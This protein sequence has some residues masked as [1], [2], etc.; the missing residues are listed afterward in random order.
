MELLAFCQSYTDLKSLKQG[1]YEH[2]YLS[3][4]QGKGEYQHLFVVNYDQVKTKFISQV[5]CESRGTILSYIDGQY[6]LVCYAFQKFFNFGAPQAHQIDWSTAKIYE[7]VDGSLLKLYYD[8]YL[9]RWTVASNRSITLNDKILSTSWN[10]ASRHLPWDRLQT[11]CVYMFELV[12]PKWKIVI[13]YV[14]DKIYHLATRDMHTLK[15]IHVDLP[16]IEHPLIYPLCS[17]DRIREEV[18]KLDQHHEGWVVIDDKYQRVKVKTPTYMSLQHVKDKSADVPTLVLQCVLKGET[19]ELLATSAQ[20]QPIIEE[21]QAKY[22]SLIQSMSAAL[23]ACK[24]LPSKKEVKSWIDEH[25]PPLPN[26]I[27]AA[28]SKQCSIDPRDYLISLK[29]QNLVKYFE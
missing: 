21:Y 2:D 17:E 29:V 14:E 16:G 27:F 9:K 20:L 10:I 19:E 5:S 3:L 24:D 7:K 22:E 4:T 26:F 18:Q 8:T 12:S 25:Q 13:S 23:L 15:E 11:N 28:Y 6:S 1:L